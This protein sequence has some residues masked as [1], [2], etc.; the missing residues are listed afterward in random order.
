MDNHK[1][2]LDIA[3]RMLSFGW[4]AGSEGTTLAVSERS[5]TVHGLHVKELVRK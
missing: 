2:D 5:V 1:L 3:T 4:N